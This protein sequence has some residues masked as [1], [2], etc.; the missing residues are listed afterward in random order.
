[1]PLKEQIMEVISGPH[2]AAVATLDGKLPAV[3]FMVLAGLPD[4]TLV[5]ATMKS[6]K[7]V[8]QLKKNP[9]TALAIWSGKEYSDPYVEIRAKGKVHEDIATKKKV[10][11][12]DARTALQNAGESGFC[13]DR[14]H[15]RRDCVSR[16]EYVKHGDLETLKK[17]PVLPGRKCIVGGMPVPPGLSQKGN[18]LF[19]GTLRE[20][21]RVAGG[22]PRFRALSCSYPHGSPGGFRGRCVLPPW[23]CTGSRQRTGSGRPRPEDTG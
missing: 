5:G 8:E 16:E 10:L 23:N 3:R 17:I 11:E 19:L 15:R 20:G 4:M 12:P 18:H 2:V 7:K 22:V 21:I 1:M 14:V 6:S 13:R 9:D